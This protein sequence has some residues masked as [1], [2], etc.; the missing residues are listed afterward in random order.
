MKKVIFKLMIIGFLY[1]LIILIYSYF[2]GLPPFHHGIV[3]GCPTIYYQF[4]SSS[5]EIQFGTTRAVNVLY[6]FFI[7]IGIY[8]CFE[9]ISKYFNSWL[10]K[11]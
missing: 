5:N 10:K 1:F 3:I 11:K 7:I 2:I 8:L 4:K 9:L 6:N